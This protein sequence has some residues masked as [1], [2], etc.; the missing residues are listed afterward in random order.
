MLFQVFGRV[1]WQSAGI[2]PIQWQAKLDEQLVFLDESYTYCKGILSAEFNDASA[3]IRSTWLSLKHI[4]YP[5]ETKR[6]SGCSIWCKKVGSTVSC[7][8]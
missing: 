1:L 8:F 3:A 5:F 7:S 6:S 4:D 2:H